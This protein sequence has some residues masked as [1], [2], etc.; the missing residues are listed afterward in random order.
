[1]SIQLLGRYFR[2]ILSFIWSFLAAPIL[3][4]LAILAI[5]QQRLTRDYPQQFR[6]LTRLLDHLLLLDLP[7]R[8]SDSAATRAIT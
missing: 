7:H 8:A 2:A 6:Q 3:A 4:I 1:L 5:A